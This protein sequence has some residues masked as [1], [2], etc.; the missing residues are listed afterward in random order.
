MSQERSGLKS[1]TAWSMNKSK[2]PEENFPHFFPKELKLRLIFLS[3]ILEV[4]GWRVLH[5]TKNTV[6]LNLHA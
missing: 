5:Y 1:F 6:T 2:D 4:G 3:A